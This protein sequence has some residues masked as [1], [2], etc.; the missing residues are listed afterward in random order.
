M[1]VLAFFNAIFFTRTEKFDLAT[2]NI[3]ILVLLVLLLLI[4]TGGYKGN[5]IF[6]IYTFPLL[7]FFLKDKKSAFLWNISFL[8]LI[9]I[10]YL[11]SSKGILTISYDMYAILEAVGA[12]LAVTFL[13]YFYA[14]ALTNL[15]KKLTYR[16]LYDPLT[17]LFNRQFVMEYLEKEI[18]KIKR[19]SENHLCVVYIDFD[20]FK[21]I[22]DKYGHIVGDEVL[23]NVA[24]IF[25][26][27]FRKSDVIGRIGGDE[28]L[29]VI[30]Y[31]RK[32]YIENK[33]ILLR[34]T[35]ENQF[36]KYNLSFSYGIVVLPDETQDFQNAIKLADKRMYKNKIRKS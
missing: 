19:G 15:T 35:I 9:L 20:N 3:L 10:I 16:A 32:E 25:L 2:T 28:F 21:P 24:R 14:D 22:N 29:I 11:L 8:F 5:G 23:K 13:A 17:D 36:K 18:E 1:S 34:E 6:W 7:T 4:I 31:C 26:E 12:Y 27:N 30:N 33:L